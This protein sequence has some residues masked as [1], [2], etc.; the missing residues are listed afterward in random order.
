MKSEYDTYM[1]QIFHLFL[2]YSTFISDCIKETR[3]TPNLRCVAVENTY[4]CMEH[5]PGEQ[6]KSPKIPW[7]VEKSYVII[8]ESLI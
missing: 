6:E 7:Q 5:S 3:E 2:K 4:E 8:Q 1:R